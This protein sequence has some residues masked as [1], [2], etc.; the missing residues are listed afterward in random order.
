MALG[1]YSTAP[2]SHTAVAGD[3]WRLGVTL[4]DNGSAFAM[5]GATV[6]AY[7]YDRNGMRIAGPVSQSSGTTGADWANG[8]LV[9]AI[10]AA[11]SDDCLP[12]DDLE[13]RINVILSGVIRT[14]VLAL[15]VTESL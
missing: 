9:V 6:N 15:S 3:D 1:Q 14:W 8:V 13:L 2:R 7:V 11:T 4:Y 5:T 10:P 12:A